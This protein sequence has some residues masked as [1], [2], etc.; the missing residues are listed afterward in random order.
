VGSVQALEK[1]M[2]VATSG[3]PTTV[4]FQIYET[5]TEALGAHRLDC[6]FLGSGTAQYQGP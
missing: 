6:D 5:I 2:F 1:G 4:Q 3:Q